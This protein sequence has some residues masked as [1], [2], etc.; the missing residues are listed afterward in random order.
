VA[1]GGG[2][3][4]ARSEVAADPYGRDLDVRQGELVGWGEVE[5]DAAE[6]VVLAILGVLRE[7]LV[8]DELGEFALEDERTS[9]LGRAAG[10][11]G[12]RSETPRDGRLFSDVARFNNDTS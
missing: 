3:Y 9:G 12:A 11:V 8:V 4:R 5:E 1:V 10:S 6:A 2:P 7:G